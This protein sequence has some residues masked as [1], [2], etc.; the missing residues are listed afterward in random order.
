LDSPLKEGKEEVMAYD[1]N[2]AERMQK[3]LDDLT[4]TGFIEKKMFG[5][6]GYLVGGNMAC[7]VHKDEMIV[8][9]GQEGFMDALN[10]PGARPFDMTGKPMSGWVMVKPS[11][12]ET[13]Q[14]LREWIILGLDYARTLPSK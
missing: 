5:G 2:L 12:F 10:R 3:I 8:R 7:G 9:V 6:V 1:K 11:G 4:L 14:A 13:D